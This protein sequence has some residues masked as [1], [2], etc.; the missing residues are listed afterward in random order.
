MKIL[1]LTLEKQWFEMIFSLEKK[2]EY[3]LIKPY[4]CSRFLIFVDGQKYR[5]KQFEQAYGTNPFQKEAI[6][7]NLKQNFFTFE[8]YEFVEFTNGY[9]LARPSMMI[10]CK[11]LSVGPGNN[12]WGAIGDEVYFK[13]QLGSI[14]SQRNIPENLIIQ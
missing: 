10:E 4:W 9:G 14:I 2:E 1:N 13:I 11:G 12:K 6:I 5:Q 3:R 7:Q 8:H